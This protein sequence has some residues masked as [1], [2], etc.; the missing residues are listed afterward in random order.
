MSNSQYARA[1]ISLVVIAS[2]M[3]L[4]PLLMYLLRNW[5]TRRDKLYGYLGKDA[6]I[7][8]YQ[9]FYPART[10]DAATIERVFHKDFSRNYGR[11]R[12]VAPVLLLTCLTGV[13]A[14]AAASTLQTW[15]SVTKGQFSLPS[16]TLS[17]LAGG[18]TWVVNDLISRIRRRDLT[19]GDVY[20][21]VFRVLVAVPFGWA[22][23]KFATPEVGVPLAFLLGVFPTGTLF[24]VGRRIAATQLKMSDDPQTGK[25]ELET[26]QS[27]TRTNAE[28]F[29][30]EGISTIVQLAYADPVDL[31]I[32]TNFD[33]SYVIDCISQ[34]L[35][36]MYFG[37]KTA[38]LQIYSLRGAQEA[39]SL[40]G[41]LSDA[42]P[43]C[44]TR[45][46]ATLKAAADALSITPDTL[47]E[48]LE[49]VACDPYSKF[50]CQI[51][52]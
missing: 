17:A 29:Y 36:W 21:G 2:A 51:W 28:R 40:Y 9:Q 42:D 6:L 4:L 16:I 47:R 39:S 7:P 15:Q 35:F 32:R 31:T 43:A 10:P 20:N 23:A 48:T 33:F 45:A 1:L 37:D 8:Y 30:D 27:I 5:V 13:S 11:R 18:F 19:V 38:A 14:Y 44:Q 46:L 52:R 41:S 49:Q 34:A 12:Y 24:T 26:L 25:L 22:L 3:V 50:I